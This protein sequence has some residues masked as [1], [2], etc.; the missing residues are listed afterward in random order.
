MKNGTNFL[1]ILMMKL[2]IMLSKNFWIGMDF[3]VPLV[4]KLLK[5]QL[6]IRPE[7]LIKDAAYPVQVVGH[8]EFCLGD[9]IVLCDK[10]LSYDQKNTVAI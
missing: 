5:V 2:L 10:D 8:T 6:W 1:S 4:M 3:S 7:S 9:F